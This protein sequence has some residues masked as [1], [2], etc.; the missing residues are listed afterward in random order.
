MTAYITL[1]ELK[2][3]LH[4]PLHDASKDEWLDTLRQAAQIVVDQLAGG[5]R[6]AVTEDETFFV[7]FSRETVIGNI[8]RLPYEVHSITQIVNGDGKIVTADEFVTMPRLASI[9]DGVVS[10]PTSTVLTARPFY[11]IHLK[12]SSSKRWTYINDWQNA[13][14]I[15][16]KRGYSSSPPAPIRLATLDL[17]THFYKVPENIGKVIIS[18]DGVML[19]PDAI[20][21]HVAGLVKMFGGGW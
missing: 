4:I 18:P 21:S 10:A 16:G 6:F 2:E 20:P 7:D 11:E 15:T 9:V 13:I 19:T 5:R 8:L 14:S 17:A 12:F 3:R 1:D